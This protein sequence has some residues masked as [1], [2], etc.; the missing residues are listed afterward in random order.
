MYITH[1]KFKVGMAKYSML[2]LIFDKEDGF[3]KLF[4]IC[5]LGEHF[6]RYVHI[7]IFVVDLH[8]IQKVHANC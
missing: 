3:S 2:N 5:A 4:K 8:G 6:R 1:T 7:I